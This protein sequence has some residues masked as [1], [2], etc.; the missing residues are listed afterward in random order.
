MSTASRG[1]APCTV[2]TFCPARGPKAMRSVHAVACS[3]LSA[4]AASVSR[5]WV[6]PGMKPSDKQ[7][8]LYDNPVSW[9]FHAVRVQARLPSQS[10]TAQNSVGS[11]LYLP[12]KV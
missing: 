11:G 10:P 5:S 7:R 9:S 12:W 4:R 3:G 6:C 8:R 1:I 2:N